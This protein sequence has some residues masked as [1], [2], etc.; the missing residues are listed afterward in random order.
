MQKIFIFHSQFSISP[1]QF[2][3]C[4][5]VIF[6][7]QAFYKYLSFFFAI[8]GFGIRTYASMP[9]ILNFPCKQYQFWER[10]RKSLKCISMAHVWTWWN[11]QYDGTYYT[12]VV[13][14][15][16]DRKINFFGQKA[17]FDKWKLKKKVLLNYSKK[18]KRENCARRMR[19]LPINF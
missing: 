2:G 9:T 6:W 11:V 8:I 3:K 15:W 18:N 12:L 14:D 7:L 1:Y 13:I 10:C 17:S 16:C 4:C 5:V 19:T